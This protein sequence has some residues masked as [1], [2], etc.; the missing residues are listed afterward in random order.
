MSLLFDHRWTCPCP[1]FTAPGQQSTG[2]RASEESEL[3]SLYE[4]VE[5]A[6]ADLI[7]DVV[8]MNNSVMLANNNFFRMI[9]RWMYKEG[10]HEQ[11]PLFWQALLR[12]GEE[13]MGGREAVFAFCCLCSPVL[14]FLIR[15]LSL[16]G[17]R[18]LYS[19]SCFACSDKRGHYRVNRPSINSRRLFPDTL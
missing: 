12:C 9:T 1:D 19:P 17:L 3:L 8:F 16:L 10:S 4:G 5:E 13:L 15:A 2:K 18:D 14:P 7:N 6:G 11:G